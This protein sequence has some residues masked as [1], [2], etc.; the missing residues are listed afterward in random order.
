VCVGVPMRVLSVDDGMALCE[1]RGET[2]RL[3]A[4]LLDGV[5]PGDFVLAFQGS[6]VRALDPAEAAQTDAALDALA[7]AME[8]AGDIDRHFADLVDRVPA[9]PPHLRK[10]R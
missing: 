4:M 3:N 2:V 7:A 9:L 8:G 5:A 1:R 6:A 10:D